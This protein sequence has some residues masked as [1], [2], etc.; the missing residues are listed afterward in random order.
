MDDQKSELISRRTFVAGTAAVGLVG[1]GDSSADLDGG[2]DAR[3]NPDGDTADGMNPDGT[4]SGAP[5]WTDVPNIAFVLGVASVFSIAEFVSDPDGDALTL[6]LNDM[7]LPAGVT[8]DAAA[9]EFRYDGV[10]PL[11]MTS[12]HVLTADDGRA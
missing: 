5:V 11:A 8:F 9:M 1:C 6:T 7:P 10:G 4:A 3:V 12:G 2:A